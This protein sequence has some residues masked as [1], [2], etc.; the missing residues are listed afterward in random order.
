MLE[1]GPGKERGW[2]LS[3][4]KDLVGVFSRDRWTVCL[5]EHAQK[6]RERRTKEGE[7]TMPLGML[8]QCPGEQGELKGAGGRMIWGGG[9]YS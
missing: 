8:G 4:A 9:G 5:R 6:E 7:F 1:R 3:A 2:S